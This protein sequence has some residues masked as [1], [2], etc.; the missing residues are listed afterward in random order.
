MR[1][2]S[3]CRSATR[4]KG[5]LTMTHRRILVAG[6][7]SLALLAAA[8]HEDPL[9]T[10]PPPPIANSNPLTLV[11]LGGRTQ[12]QAMKDARPTFVSVWAGNNDLLGGAEAGDTTL[13]TDTAAFRINYSR[14]L[15]SIEA[16]GASAVLIAVGLGHLANNVVLPFFSRGTT[17]F[18]LAAGGAF[19]P[20]PFTVAANCAPPRGDTVLVSF[21]YGFGL[22]ATAQ[23]GTATTLDCTAP[24]VIEPAETRFFALRQLRYNA[25]IQAEAVARGWPFTDS[26]NVTMDSLAAVLPAGSQFAPFPNTAAACSGSPFG[27]AFSCD[28]LHPS[29][30]THQRIARKIVRAIN[31]QYGSAIP[32]P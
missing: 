29:Q 3:G 16:T 19:A 30:A 25:I 20:A 11:F 17:W 18:G 8:C 24:P 12:V 26:V 6:G 23:G 22:L 9:F 32:Q 27:L 2:C 7:L 21:A 28:G 1:T 4:S 15:D 10:T 31:A 14:A 5:A 13:A